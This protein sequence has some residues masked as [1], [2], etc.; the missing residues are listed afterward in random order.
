[1]LVIY[2]L[3]NNLLGNAIATVSSSDKIKLITVRATNFE[4]DV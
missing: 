2:Y 3:L 4:K 1:M